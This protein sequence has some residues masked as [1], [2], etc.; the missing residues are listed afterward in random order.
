MSETA[1]QDSYSGFA[2]VELYG[3]R[4]VA[5]RVAPVQQFGTEML[6]VDVPGADGETIITQFYGGSSIYGLTPCSEETARRVVAQTY[7]LP[8]LV[9]LAIEAAKPTVEPAQLTLDRVRFPQRD[10]DGEDDDETAY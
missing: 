2:V 9:K 4:K 5:G 6:R 7:D 10:D 8:D 3:H 1:A